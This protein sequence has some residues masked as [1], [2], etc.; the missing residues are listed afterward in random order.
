MSPPGYN[1]R[2][3]S[4]CAE[5]DEEAAKRIEEAAKR[6]RFTSSSWDYYYYY[7]NV[8][9]EEDDAAAG[10]GSWRAREAPPDHVRYRALTLAAKHSRTLGLIYSTLCPIFWVL[11]CLFFMYIDPPKCT[12]VEYA[13][14]NNITGE[15]NRGGSKERCRSNG[16]FFGCFYGFFCAMA[17]WLVFYALSCF[18]FVCCIYIQIKSELP[19]SLTLLRTGRMGIFCSMLQDTRL[20]DEG[21]PV[22]PPCICMP[23]CLCV[24]FHTKIYNR[25]NICDTQ[26]MEDKA[27]D[28]CCPD[29]KYP[30]T[31]ADRCRYALPP[32]DHLQQGVLCCF[33]LPYYILMCVPYY[34]LMCV[35]F[36]SI[37]LSRG[38]GNG[39]SS[40]GGGGGGICGGGGCGGG[41]GG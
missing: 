29:P 6:I 18:V 27:F 5:I 17:T 28:W 14:T 10:G 13:S 4:E 33:Y 8:E 26:S 21:L 22:Y 30:P 24:Y 40:S 15:V 20:R 7:D 36:I 3:G 16:V 35:G 11:W 9:W 38:G 19:Q 39:G 25:E 34:I 12:P 1:P 32:R 37:N 23:I 41:C 31:M 2:T